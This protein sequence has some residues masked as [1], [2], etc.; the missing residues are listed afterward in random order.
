MQS[1]KPSRPVTPLKALRQSPCRY[2]WRTRPR[3]RMAMTGCSFARISTDATSRFGGIWIQSGERSRTARRPTDADADLKQAPTD[4]MSGL[5]R[6][7]PRPEEVRAPARH[8]SALSE[9]ALDW[10]ITLDQHTLHDAA[11]AYRIVE[12]DAMHGG[13]VVPHHD[14]AGV[15]DMAEMVLRLARFGAQL[16]EQ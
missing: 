16:V 15:P 6:G 14:V 8:E 5:G 2:S 7:N 13:A 12:H 3:S 10:A 9:F 4:D 1:I 11:L